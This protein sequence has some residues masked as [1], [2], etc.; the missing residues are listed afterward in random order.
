MRYLLI[1]EMRRRE[2]KRGGASKAWL[3]ELREVLGREGTVA[4]ALG[5]SVATVSRDWTFAQ[6]WLYR[7]VKQVLEGGALQSLEGKGAK[8]RAGASGEDAAA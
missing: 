6:A 3:E 8:G 4:E 7:V 1:S 2:Q 5:I